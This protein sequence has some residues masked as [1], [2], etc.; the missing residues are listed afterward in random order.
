M[1][2]EE[3]KKEDGD[4][5]EGEGEDSLWR[6]Y[7]EDCETIYETGVNIGPNFDFR[8]ERSPKPGYSVLL[9][10][11]TCGNKAFES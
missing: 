7:A 10:A 8:Y 9:Y 6:Y 1:V 5:K 4:Q 2:E 3:E 11:T